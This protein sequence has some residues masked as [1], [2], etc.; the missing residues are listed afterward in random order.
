MVSIT[1]Q[2]HPKRFKH[3]LFYLCPS[4]IEAAQKQYSDGVDDLLKDLEGLCGDEQFQLRKELL[5]FFLTVFL[6][7]LQTMGGDS[8]TAVTKKSHYSVT[9][10]YEALINKGGDLQKGGID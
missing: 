4:A 2:P 10:A 5:C 9:K 8:K 3:D 1:T 6:Y 7:C